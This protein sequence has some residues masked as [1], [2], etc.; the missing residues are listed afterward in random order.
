LDSFQPLHAGAIGGHP[1]RPSDR[2]RRPG[3]HRGALCITGTHAKD[4]LVKEVTSKL[5]G[6]C[7]G[8][9]KVLSSGLFSFPRVMNRHRRI[10]GGGARSN[11]TELVSSAKTLDLL[12]LPIGKAG[13]RVAVSVPPFRQ[14]IGEENHAQEVADGCP[15]GRRHGSSA[16]CSGVGGSNA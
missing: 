5:W 14:T 7:G 9:L 6:K 8:K 4:L 2:R 15:G 3:A 1:P 12:A 16:C 11:R 13:N 10:I